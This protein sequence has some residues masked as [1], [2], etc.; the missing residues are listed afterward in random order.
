MAILKSMTASTQEELTRLING[1]I[2]SKF[3]L[4][5]GKDQRPNPAAA[6][7]NL[8]KHPLNGKTLIFTAP[9]VTV[10]FSADVDFKE[11]V[12]QINTQAGSEVA[13]LLKETSNG[14]LLLVLWNDVTPVVLSETG[15]ANAYFGF[16]TT[17][18]DPLLTQTPIDPTKIVSIVIELQGRK[19]VC[20]YTS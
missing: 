2:K 3:N 16:S 8:Y 5:M 6:P 13:H 20:F 18:A 19:F 11:I 12:D 4:V 1:L 14:G 9:A 15:T 10:T 7:D 17:A